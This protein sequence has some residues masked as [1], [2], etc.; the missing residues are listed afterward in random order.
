MEA[1]RPSKPPSLAD[2]VRRFFDGKAPPGADRLAALEG[3]CEELRHRVSEADERG[4]ARSELFMSLQS[5]Y[6]VEHFE[7]QESMRNLKI[8][9]MRNAGMFADRDIVLRRAKALQARIRS[10]KERL[11]RH[12]TVEDEHFDDAPIV[13]ENKGTDQGA[14]PGS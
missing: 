14:G 2:R 6:S 13:I 4:R 1:R 9:R 10:L 7:L 3:E 11:R 8:E 5:Q 12:E